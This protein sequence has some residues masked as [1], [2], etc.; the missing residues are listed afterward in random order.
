MP[1]IYRT[2]ARAPG[3]GDEAPER[4]SRRLGERREGDELWLL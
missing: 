1:Q 2:G 4:A 3:H